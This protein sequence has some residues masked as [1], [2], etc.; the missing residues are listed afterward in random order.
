[1]ARFKHYVMPLFLLLGHGSMYQSNLL[2]AQGTPQPA[3]SASA[4]P[5][6]DLN[7]ANWT[8]LKQ[9][10]GV[11]DAYA[12]RIVEGRPYSSKNQLVT[13]G[14]LPPAAYDRIK[15][16]IVAKRAAKP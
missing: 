15:D 5:Q 2:L 4:V 7:T 16:G 13:R 10:P 1:M 3:A 6:L 9:L 11:G 8:Q 14:I 12:K